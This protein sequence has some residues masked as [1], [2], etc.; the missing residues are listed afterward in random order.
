MPHKVNPIDFENAEGN[1]GIANAMLNHFSA[2]LPISRWQRDL[3]D[4]TVLR[5]LGVAIAHCEIG[6]QSLLKGMSKLEINTDQLD[7][8][9]NKNIEVLAEPIQTVMRKNKVSGA[10]EKL[11]ELTR[12][13]KLD[14]EKLETFISSLELP[15]EDK[16]HLQKLTASNYV[17]IASKL[18]KKE[19]TD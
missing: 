9:L 19:S 13:Q 16:D 12:G 11:K 17:G 1:F 5:N 7:I 14:V 6:Y 8:D 3:S 15:E 2:K 4:S 18:A 10:Y